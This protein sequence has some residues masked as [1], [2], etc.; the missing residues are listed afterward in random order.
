MSLAQRVLGRFLL[1]EGFEPSRVDLSVI[2][3]V[4]PD[5]LLHL[6]LLADALTDQDGSG[7]TFGD[8]TSILSRCVLTP[9]GAMRV[10]SG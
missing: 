2:E 4:K 9:R 10:H 7:R 3:F 5:V 8:D 1:A 6:Q